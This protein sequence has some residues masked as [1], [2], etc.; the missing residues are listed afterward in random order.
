MDGCK[1]F[2][3]KA[4]AMQIG[5]GYC[6]GAVEAVIA[7]SRLDQ[8]HMFFCP[9]PDATTGTAIKSVIEYEAKAS[10]EIKL[11]PFIMYVIEALHSKWPCSVVALILR[12]SS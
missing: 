4:R 10:E 6:A 1:A 7:V 5:A 12:P 9:P 8:Q 11:Q 2:V 3:A